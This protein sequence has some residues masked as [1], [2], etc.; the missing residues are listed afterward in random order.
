MQR[1]MW[2]EKAGWLRGIR[3]SRSRPQA[4]ASRAVSSKMEADNCR[5]LTAALGPDSPACALR[6]FG[7]TCCLPAH[8]HANHAHRGCGLQ[9]RA[10][11][12]A[13]GLAFW[14]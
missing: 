1:V 11:G 8:E 2:S 14:G 10:L 7:D 6:T 3:R 5:E 4:A 12:E 9:P 13:S